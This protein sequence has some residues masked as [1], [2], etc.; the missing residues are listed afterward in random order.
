MVGARHGRIAA[1]V[2]GHNCKVRRTQ[3]TLET[4]QP[5][6]ELFE[7]IAVACH[8]VAVAELLIEIHQV[9]EN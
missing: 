9:H 1:V 7:R 6:V 8:I 2:G 5:G 3:R 4:R